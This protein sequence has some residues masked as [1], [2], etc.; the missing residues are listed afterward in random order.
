[1]IPLGF[2][3][4]ISSV[5]SNLNPT[6]ESCVKSSNSA[7]LVRMPAWMEEVLEM[8]PSVE[9]FQKKLPWVTL[10]WSVQAPL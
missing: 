1:M 3:S 4:S 9:A 6:S 8:S 2:N 7:N 5:V 10:D